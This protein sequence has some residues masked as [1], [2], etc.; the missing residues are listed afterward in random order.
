MAG[1]SCGQ[2][3]LSCNRVRRFLER[4]A[5]YF[6][7]C[8]SAPVGRFMLRTNLMIEP[9]NKLTKALVRF[10]A[11]RTP[12]C[13]DVTRLLSESMEHPLPLR[14]RFLLRLHFAICI[15]CQRYGE[16]LKWLRRY[17]S[18][19]PTRGCEHG[20]ESLSSETRERIRK[21]VQEI[22]R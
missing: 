22:N 15:W 6:D 1:R 8:F 7:D 17:G 4:S 18:G 14:T 3:V 5:I 11:N 21:A 20:P 16:H 10:L 2:I 13:H 9:T 12:H 19:F